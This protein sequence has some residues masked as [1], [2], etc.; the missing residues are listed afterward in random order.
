MTKKMLIWG[1][2]PYHPTK[3]QSGWFKEVFEPK[4]WT[5]DY[6]EDRE[7]FGTESL[8]SAD[9]FVISG[10]DDAVVTPVAEEQY[11]ETPSMRRTSYTP[12]EDKYV[13]S[14]LDYAKAGKPLFVFHG[15]ILAFP[16][17]ARWTPLFDGRWVL[18][19]THHP[20]YGK[21]TVKSSW[22]A[23]GM[24]PGFAASLLEGIPKTFEIEDECYCDLLGPT[25]SQ[26][27]LQAD[28]EGKTHT[29]AWAGNYGPS[30][31]AY[32]GLG[33]DMNTLKSPVLTQFVENCVGW[34]AEK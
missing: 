7:A 28:M 4:G 34:L 29:L 18:G 8:A 22:V 16:D 25:H 19:Q 20:P 13:N 27:L 31:V 17:E 30:R 33:H 6:R 10:F 32:C 12:L 26:V 1:G 5:I 2:G 23:A 11:W 3:A 9:L 24:G 21:F 15:G 14:L